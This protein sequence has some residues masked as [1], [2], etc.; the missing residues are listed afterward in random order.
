[1]QRP[2]LMPSASVTTAGK[3]GRG[4]AAKLQITLPVIYAHGQP[5]Q[6]VAPTTPLKP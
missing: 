6:I 4:L 2:E 5:D 3:E 1:M